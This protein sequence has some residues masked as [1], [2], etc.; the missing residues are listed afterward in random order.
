V[1]SAIFCVG[2]SLPGCLR[3]SARVGNE[4]WW[5][6]AEV[7]GDFQKLVQAR[8]EVR[9]WL[10]H[11]PNQALTRE[12]IANRKRQAAHFDGGSRRSYR[13]MASFSPNRSMFRNLLCFN[14]IIE[15]KEAVPG[16]THGCC[17]FSYTSYDGRIFRPKRFRRRD[18]FQRQ[19][20]L[21][22]KATNLAKEVHIRFWPQILRDP[23]TG[24]E[25]RTCEIQACI[26]QTV[27]EGLS[28]EIHRRVSGR[29]IC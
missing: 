20:V 17:A 11:C 8:A 10:A 13:E 26:N 24:K 28:F 5:A 29:R 12:H 2:V 19:S 1:A 22:G 7:D 27:G 15:T 21:D 9:V 4:T 16:L 23:E 14:D 6:S 3:H 25:G 18:E